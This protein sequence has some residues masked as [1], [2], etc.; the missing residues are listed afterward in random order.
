MPE[1]VSLDELL[2]VPAEDALV[3]PGASLLDALAPLPDA[4]EGQGASGREP[5]I[6]EKRGREETQ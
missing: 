4:A 6:G 3:P 5:Q 2:P 1:I